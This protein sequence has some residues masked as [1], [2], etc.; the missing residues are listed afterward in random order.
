MRGGRRG[1]CGGA[2]Q[3][4][5][6]V[7][8]SHNMAK[9]LAGPQ[10]R[11]GVSSCPAGGCRPRLEQEGECGGLTLCGGHEGSFVFLFSS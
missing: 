4:S 9:A 1:G 2:E 10:N 3:A 6:V 5:T 11:S 7:C 8:C